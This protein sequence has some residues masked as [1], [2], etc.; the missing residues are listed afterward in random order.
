MLAVCTK[1]QAYGLFGLP[2]LGLAVRAYG[3][4]PGRSTG[5]KAMALV[6]APHIWQ[7]IVAGIG[8]FVLAHNLLF[9]LQGFESHLR[10]IQNEG[11]VQFRMFPM[12]PSG[13]WQLWQATWMLIRISMGWPM[14]VVL[15]AGI[16][17]SLVP[18]QR[19]LW[20]LMLPAISYFSTFLAVTGFTYDR[21]L[22]P[23][24]MVLALF[25]GFAAERVEAL[26]PRAAT[27]VRVAT[28]AVLAYSVVYVAAVD[29]AMLRDS[30]YDVEAWLRTNVAPGS[31][32]GL[33]GGPE[34]VPRIDDF[35]SQFLR[36]TRDD[37]D[38]TTFDYI[39][40][41]LDW[42]TRW[43]PERVEH[44]L[45]VKLRENAFAYRKVFEARSDVGFGGLAFDPR[46]APFG[47]TGY[48]TLTKINPPLLVFKRMP[49]AQLQI[50]Q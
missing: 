18:F 2:A 16:A 30:R 25:V 4:A 49:A 38:S 36:P 6:R 28:F 27:A 41:N 12:T 47:T 19:R 35:V 14:F 5:E 20:W 3:R 44:E 50:P 9:N 10:F 42:M 29:V 33:M 1:D 17:L 13:V 45:L 21:F 26:V 37:L 43:G 48:S 40:V 15:L 8:T 31:R 32:I 23:V 11:S 7:S 34:H 46:F 24:L 22:L 39:V